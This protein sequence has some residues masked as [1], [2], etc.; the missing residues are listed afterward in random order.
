MVSHRFRLPALFMALLALMAQLG[1]GA[2]VP[3]A[4]PIAAAGVLCHPHHNSDGTPSHAPAHLPDCPVCPLC[5]AIHA[6]APTLVAVITAPPPPAV[7][8][9]A[10]IER[11]PPATAAPAMPRPP[12]QPRAPPTLS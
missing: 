10:T 6:P 4:D 2:S 1:V 9:T 12:A 7:A 3:R 5:A 11:P 8:V